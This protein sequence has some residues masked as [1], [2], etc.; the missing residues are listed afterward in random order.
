MAR[1]LVIDDDIDYLAMVKTFLVDAGYEVFPLLRADK[2]LEE[3]RHLPPDLV[4]LDILMPG[5]TGGQ[6]YKAIRREFGG[7]LP[8]L[9]VTG[10]DITL[11]GVED[12]NLKYLR[13]PVNLDTLLKAVRSMLPEEKPK[14]KK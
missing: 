13:K 8:I 10:T 11:K 6:C 2:A 9:I 7:L 5:I 4:I 1:I 12:S 3:M 14:D